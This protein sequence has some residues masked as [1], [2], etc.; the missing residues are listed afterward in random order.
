MAKEKKM[1][2][3]IT[4]MDVIASTI[5]FSFAMIFLLFDFLIFKRQGNLVNSMYYLKN[6]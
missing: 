2:E 1:V 6:T 3:A 5:F 4:S